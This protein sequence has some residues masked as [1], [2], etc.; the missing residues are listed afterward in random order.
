[1][2]LE[3]TFEQQEA[4]HMSI[5]SRIQTVKKLIAGWEE[6]PNEFT[7]KLIESYTEELNILVEMESKIL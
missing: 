1:M 3:L 5:L 7:P 2:K 6:Y 4:L